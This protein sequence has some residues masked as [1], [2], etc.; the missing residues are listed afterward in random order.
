MENK[1]FT[2]SD[3]QLVVDPATGG[4]SLRYGKDSEVVLPEKLL[5]AGLVINDT[6]AATA[7][8]ILINSA[9]A[10]SRF[11]SVGTQGIVYIDGSIIIPNRGDLEIKAGCILKRNDYSD[12]P[13]I[14]NKADGYTL[15][16]VYFS[17]SGSNVVTVVDKNHT[18]NVGDTVSIRNSQVSAYNGVFTVTYADAAGWKYVCGSSGTDTAGATNYYSFV[19]PIL[20]TIAPASVTN[21]LVSASVTITIAAPGVITWTAHGL[22]PNQ[23]IRFSTTGALN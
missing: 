6:T 13:V 9:L 7:N 5:V 22:G 2:Y 1:E 8:R 4:K 3:L 18:F 20:R 21:A 10:S 19:V 12:V 11:V 16:G 15:E 17:R 14:K 23:A